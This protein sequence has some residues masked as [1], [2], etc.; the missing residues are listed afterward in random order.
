MVLFPYHLQY[1]TLVTKCDPC[2]G[3]FWFETK[4]TQIAFKVWVINMICSFETIYIKG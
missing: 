3:W 1:H 4:T 2:W